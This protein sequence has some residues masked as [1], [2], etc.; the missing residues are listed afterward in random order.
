MRMQLDR[1]KDSDQ[2]WIDFNYHSN[3]ISA[4]VED[5]ESPNEEVLQLNTCLLLEYPTE[6]SFVGRQ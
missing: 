1:P 3:S 4:Y 6:I 5:M 2:F